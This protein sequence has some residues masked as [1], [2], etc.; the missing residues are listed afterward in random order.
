[1]TTAVNRNPHV[2]QPFRNIIND[3]RKAKTTPQAAPQDIIIY[4]HNRSST[5]WPCDAADD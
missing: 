1:M 2:L 3:L 4:T 5:S